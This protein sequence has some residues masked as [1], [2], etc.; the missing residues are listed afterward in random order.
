LFGLLNLS[1]CFL[2]YSI[3]RKS[4][5]T[6]RFLIIFTFLVIVIVGL[7]GVLW[8]PKFSSPGYNDLPNSSMTETSASEGG[9]DCKD[10]L[11]SVP[12]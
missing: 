10:H 2:D 12:L 9:K 11:Y 1:Q 8:N 4:L 6:V 7:L 5:K 3:I